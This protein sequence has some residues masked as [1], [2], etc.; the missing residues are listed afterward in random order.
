MKNSLLI[1]SILI[2][3][4]LMGCGSTEEQSL[5]TTEYMVAMITDYGDITN[6]SFNQ[7]M[8][9]SCKDFT[10]NYHIPFTYYKPI[11]NSTA[12][13][14][15]M[16]DKAIDEGYN[17]IVM[18]GYAFGEVLVEVAEDYPNIKFIA[19]DVSEGDI[20]KAGVTAKGETYDDIP[21]HWN[22]KDYYHWDNVYCAVFKDELSGYMAGYAAVRLGYR[23]LGFLGGMAV[24]S[25]NRFGYGFLQGADAAAT[26][27]GVFVNV[28][29]A[30]GNQFFGDGDITAAMDTWYENGTEVVFACG[31][32]IYTSVAEAAVKSGGKV[33]GIDTDQ[34]A[35]I[36]GVYGDGI[37]V[38]SAMKGIYPATYDTLKDII[39]EG[40][41]KHYA[42]KIDTLAL[43]SATEPEL[44]YVQ[45]PMETT[46][47]TDSFTQEDYKELIANMYEERIVV[48]DDIGKEPT[49]RSIR[50]EYLGN[51]K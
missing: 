24:A 50:V 25:V 14:I 37:T 28:K 29:Y 30:Y 26:E 20:L 8:Y 44:N 16:V 19:L 40:K 35:I 18:S 22:V 43:V 48:V 13:R 12:D 38:T 6:Q 42:G 36:D 17:I 46:R 45:L 11:A 5:N 47:W 4:M 51:I 15:A 49:V 9:D 33:I 41:W 1:I 23:E 34:S 39:L 7:A 32:G 2:I 3:N 10:E 21:E 31:G 27:L